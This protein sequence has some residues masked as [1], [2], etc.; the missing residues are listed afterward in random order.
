[1]SSK[2]LNLIARE[3]IKSENR[4]IKLN[5]KITIKRGL[6]IEITVISANDLDIYSNLNIKVIDKILL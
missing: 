4:K 2:K 5:C 3:S 6:P 1:M